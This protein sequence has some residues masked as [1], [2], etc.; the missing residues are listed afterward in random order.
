MARDSRDAT[1]TWDLAAMGKEGPL[2]LSPNLQWVQ[3][4]SAG[5]GQQVKALGLDRTD[6]M[7]TTASGIHARPLAEFVM[8]SLLYHIKRFPML[9]EEQR[10]H[11]WQRYCGEG[12]SGKTLALLGPGRIGREVARL[13]SAFGMTVHALARDENPG[14]AGEL[15]VARVFPRAELRAMLAGSDAVVLAMPQTP[16]TEGMI[17]PAELAAMKRGAILINIARGTIV[18]EPALIDALRSGQ[19][20]FAALDVTAVEPLPADSPLWDLPNVLISPHSASTVAEENAFITERFIANLRHYL[21][22]DL[23]R[24]GPQLDKARLY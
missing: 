4:T 7:V 22:G 15:G 11:Q 5:V 2:D 20:G 10:A 14:R 16:E 24:M 19:V 3:T 8:A 23:D 1:V 12:L 6:V 18:D 21:T 13:A 17:G 9:Q